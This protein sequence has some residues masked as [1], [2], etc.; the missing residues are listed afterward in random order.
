ML[1]NFKLITV[2]HKDLNAEDLEHFVIKHTSDEELTDQLH[3]LKTIF[4]QEEI[5]YLATCNRVIFLFYGKNKLD[6]K[7]LNRIINQINPAITQ[8]RFYYLDRIV[9]FY[10]GTT[11]IRHLF[12]VAS[13]IDSLVIGEREI[14]HQFRKAYDF[15]KRQKLCGDNIRLVENSIVQASKQVYT[16]TA[17]GDRPVSVVSLAI[18]E[19]LKRKLDKEARILLVGAGETNRTAGRFLAKHGYKNLIIFNRSLNNAQELSDELKAEARHLNSLNE[20]REGYDAIFACTS[21]QDPILTEEVFN[22]ITIDSSN[23]LIID[24]SIPRNVAKAVSVLE[25]VDYISVDS[26]RMLAEQ[27]LKYR[28]GNIAAARII[29]NE[30]VAEFSKKYER[31]KVERALTNLP[32]EIHKVK[33]RALNLVY[34]EK[35][36]E[37]SPEAQKLIDEI[38]TY[39]EKKCVAIP[40]KMAKENMQP[41]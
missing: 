9:R 8:A 13:S 1:D 24:L 22:Q 41:S 15:C 31:R 12:E 23:K 6:N 39:M 18:Q 7:D 4:R 2:S 38:A 33:D 3:Q 16:N 28:R 5:F 35:I 40:M 17:I 14:F 37:L 19:F 20:Y 10:S 32:K 11:G 29:L 30:F 26:I 27:N 21:S 34:K 25:Y 36:S